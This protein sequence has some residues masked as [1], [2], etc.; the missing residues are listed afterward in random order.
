VILSEVERSLD[1]PRE[2]CMCY[3]PVLSGYGISC[4]KRKRQSVVDGRTRGKHP[5]HDD[6]EAVAIVVRLLYNVVQ[7]MVVQMERSRIVPLKPKAIRQNLWD[8]SYLRCYGTLF[9][10]SLLKSVHL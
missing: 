2:L 5:F 4:L 3:Q 6:K 8:I 10:R 9:L 7:I 1:I